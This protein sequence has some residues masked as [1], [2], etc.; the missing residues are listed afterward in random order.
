MAKRLYIIVLLLALKACVVGNPNTPG[1]NYNPNAYRQN[2]SYY[3]PQPRVAQ[4]PYPSNDDLY[5][6]NTYYQGDD[7]QS[8]YQGGYVTQP[9][10]A[11]PQQAQPVQQYQPQPVRQVQPVQPQR[12]IQQQVQ[13][14][15][16]PVYQDNDNNYTPIDY[17][18]SY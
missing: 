16:A 2:S 13:P 9:R 17:Y 4:K 14:Q 8:L 10:Y 18:F 7:P 12:Q 6:N 11:I 3:Q 1:G 5:Y 15:A